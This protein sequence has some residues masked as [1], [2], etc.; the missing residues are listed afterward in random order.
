MRGTVA[1]SA[2][3]LLA[4]AGTFLAPTLAQAHVGISSGPA[5]A[6]ATSEIV[7]GVGHGCSGLDTL[8]IKIDIPAS[9]TAVRAG[10]SDL[11]P[12]TFERNAAL[13]ITAVT[14][15]KPEGALTS[16]D[17]NYYKA[18]LRI[19]VPNTPFATLY[20]PVHQTCKA[21]GGATTTVVDWVGTTPNDAHDSD[22]GAAPEPAAALIIVPAS[23]PGWN[24][25]TVPSAIPAAS[26]PAI[27]GT[28]QVVWKGS[29]AY[30]AN[31]TTVEQI[32]STAGV[33][34]LTELAAGDEVWVKY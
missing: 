10:G 7:F 19:K 5:V 33:T 11:G 8:S 30:S 25:F 15:T 28:A 26:L 18:V 16:G 24:K 4:L 21:K 2:S 23:K 31:P 22:A 13:A 27:F 17:D 14:F 20:F 3:A 29:A 6:N 34:A 32:K 12:A 1:A 9:V